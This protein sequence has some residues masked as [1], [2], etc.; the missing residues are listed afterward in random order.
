MGLDSLV[1]L[2]MYLLG[3]AGLMLVGQG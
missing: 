1:V 2:A 3:T